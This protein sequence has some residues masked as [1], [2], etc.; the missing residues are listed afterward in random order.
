MANEEV[1]DKDEEHF[2]EVQRNGRCQ[3]DARK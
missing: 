2:E 3:E 1:V